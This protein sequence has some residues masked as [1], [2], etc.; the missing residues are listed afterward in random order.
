MTLIIASL[1]P[2]PFYKGRGGRKGGAQAATDNLT[3]MALVMDSKVENVGF[4]LSL[5]AL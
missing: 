5:K 4:P 1:P 3:P 2:L